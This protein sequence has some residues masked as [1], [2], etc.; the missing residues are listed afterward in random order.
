[1]H[2]LRL[3]IIRACLWFLSSFLIHLEGDMSMFSITFWKIVSQRR[4]FFKFE[5]RLG[6]RLRGLRL[7]IPIIWLFSKA[8]ISVVLW[9]TTLWL[10]D[11]VTLEKILRK[12]PRLNLCQVSFLFVLFLEHK[13]L[14]KTRRFKFKKLHSR[15]IGFQSLIRFNLPFVEVKVSLDLIRFTFH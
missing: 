12:V 2:V 9:F 5:T 8:S 11:V 14:T 7:F 13:W 10:L 15:S 1:M 3:C 6:F 4:F